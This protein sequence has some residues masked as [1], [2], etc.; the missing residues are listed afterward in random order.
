MADPAF[1]AELAGLLADYTGRPSPIT[2]A[3]RFAATHAGGA[4]DRCSSART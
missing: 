1:A 4:D 3:P 2:E